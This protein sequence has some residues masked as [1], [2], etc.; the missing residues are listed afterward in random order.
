MDNDQKTTNK[1]WK[2]TCQGSPRA[3]R[4]DQETG[5]EESVGVKGKEQEPKGGGVEFCAFKKVK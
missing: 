1:E 2:G 4:E 3:R 5:I